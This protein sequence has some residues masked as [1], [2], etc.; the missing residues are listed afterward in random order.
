MMLPIFFL[1][2]GTDCEVNGGMRDYI[3]RYY[4]A[5]EARA[6]LLEDYGRVIQCTHPYWPVADQIPEWAHIACLM[7]GGLEPIQYWRYEYGWE[8][9]DGD[10]LHEGD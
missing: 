4:T 5:A 8:R 1:F 9:W 6:G 3:G 10:D 2:A 7:P